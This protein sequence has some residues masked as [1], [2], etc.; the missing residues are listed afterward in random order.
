MKKK[1]EIRLP[2]PY[3]SQ[4]LA[5]KKEIDNFVEPKEWTIISALD[6]VLAKAKNCRL[7]DKFWSDC[8][9]PLDFLCQKLGL[10]DMQVVVLAILVEEGSEMSWRR[11]AEYLDCSRLTVMTY[12]DEMDELVE[13][14]W[15]LRE[16]C[17]EHARRCEGFRLAKGV[18]TSLR[19]NEVFVPEKI[20]G[21]EPHEFI[22]KL[23]KRLEC[24]IDFDPEDD[25]K[26][27][28]ASCRE[29]V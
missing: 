4:L 12:T 8:R 28:R 25:D 13:K 23:A 27:G 16:C 5:K 6:R 11:I 19:H 21:L 24:E 9:N 14:R 26:I 3:R 20:E 15:I 2:E 22:F 17:H 18:V 29:R 10:K 1:H 7:S